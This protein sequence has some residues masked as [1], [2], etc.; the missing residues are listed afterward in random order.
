MITWENCMIICNLAIELLYI[1]WA[2]IDEN[3]RI[4]K[5]FEFP[6]QQWVVAYETFFIIIP[7]I[8]VTYI[9]IDTH[10]KYCF[11]YWLEEL[12]KPNDAKI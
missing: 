4:I 11:W 9:E 2:I 3:S 5:E 10:L 7:I 1:S 8:P 6:P 12:I